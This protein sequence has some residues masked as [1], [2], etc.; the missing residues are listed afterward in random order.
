MTE[1]EDKSSNED[2]EN[3]GNSTSDSGCAN[4]LMTFFAYAIA[5]FLLHQCTQGTVVFGDRW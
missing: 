5:A 4:S 2:H 1:Q 3:K